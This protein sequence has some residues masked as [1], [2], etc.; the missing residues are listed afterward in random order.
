MQS[1]NC[2]SGF[3]IDSGDCGEFQTDLLQHTTTSHHIFPLLQWLDLNHIKYLILDMC[4]HRYNWV[5]SLT[6]QVSLI[7]IL[8]LVN[9]TS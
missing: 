5:T 8:V 4:R 1:H 3:D 7:Q 2:T 9:V 6:C